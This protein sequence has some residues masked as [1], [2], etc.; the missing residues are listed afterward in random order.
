MSKDDGINLDIFEVVKCN[1]V[2]VIVL[3][4]DVIVG[5]NCEIDCRNGFIFLLLMLIV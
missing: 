1:G 5:G 2:K 4:V 3:I